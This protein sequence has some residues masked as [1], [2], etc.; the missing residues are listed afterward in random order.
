MHRTRYA[1]R[2]QIIRELFRF[3]ISCRYNSVPAVPLYEGFFV[4]SIR[5]RFLHCACRGRPKRR[6]SSLKFEICDLSVGFITLPHGEQCCRYNSVPA[7]P[8]YEG[9]FVISIR[10]RFL[11]CACRGRP[12][13]RQ[14]SLKFEICDLSVGF[15]TLPHGEQCC[16]Y[17][18]VPAVPLYEG[19]FVISIRIRFLHCAC[20]G[21]PK[22]RQS[23][24]KFEICD[25]SVGFITLPHGEQCCRYNSV[26]A[27]PLYEGFLSFRFEFVFFIVHAGVGQKDVSRRLNSKIVTCL[28]VIITLPHGEQCC[29]YNSVPAVPLYEEFF[30]IS[31][32]I[33]F[34]HCACRGRPKWR[35]SSLK[36]EICDLSV[37]FITLPPRRA[38]LPIYFSARRSSCIIPHM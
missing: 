6:Q 10:I 36:F 23:S 7:V 15:I 12:K 32:R 21:R 3:I 31:I 28:L 25:L 19:F 30:V 38:M 26:P 35:Q 33:R 5:I 29:R 9:F 37:G 4:I 22:R 27:V 34:L 11:H 18:S 2:S 17:N 16:R 13:R 1:N 20:R 14:S 8:L 24:L